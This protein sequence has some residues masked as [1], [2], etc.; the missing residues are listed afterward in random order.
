[1]ETKEVVAKLTKV[2]D[3]LNEFGWCRGK[4][5]DTSGR[6]CIWGAVREVDWDHQ[7][8]LTDLLSLNIINQDYPFVEL[9]E[10]N[11]MDTRRKRDVIRL[12]DRTIKNLEDDA[13]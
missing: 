11:D 2:K 1:M 12:I 6:H 3:L 13:K 9:T 4:Y 7:D 8:L 5:T 10:W